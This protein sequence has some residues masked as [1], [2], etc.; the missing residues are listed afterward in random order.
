[1]AGCRECI[2][3][4]CPI[5]PV[6][7]AQT[8]QRNLEKGLDVDAELEEQ[9]NDVLAGVRSRAATDPAPTDQAEEARC[10]TPW[11]HA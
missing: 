4:T 8:W 3:V 2:E 5:L 11:P 6:Q 10:V 1:M 7:P 9:R